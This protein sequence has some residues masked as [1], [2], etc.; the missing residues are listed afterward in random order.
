MKRLLKVTE[1]H[2]RW[3]PI[4]RACTRRDL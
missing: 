3:L 1:G 4:D 2:Q